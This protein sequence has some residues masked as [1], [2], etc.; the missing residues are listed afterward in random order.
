MGEYTYEKCCSPDILP[1][2]IPITDSADV[3]GLSC[4]TEGFTE[5]I[6][7]SSDASP[8]G[9][10][11]CWMGEYT[12]EKCCFSQPTVPNDIHQACWGGNE[13]FQKICCDPFGQDPHCW[14]TGSTYHD[15]CKRGS[16]EVASLIALR[17]KSV[18]E[19][20]AKPNLELPFQQGP[21]LCQDI[22]N[23]VDK[24]VCHYLRQAEDELLGHQL[25]SSD[26]SCWSGIF[27]RDYCCSQLPLGNPHCWANELTFETCCLNLSFPVSVLHQFYRCENCLSVFQQPSLTC[28]DIAPCWHRGT[29]VAL[30]QGS[31]RRSLFGTAKALV[32][33]LPRLT[34][35]KWT[36]SAAAAV[37][38]MQWVK[39]HHRTVTQLDLFHVPSTTMPEIAVML[40]PWLVLCI[41]STLGGRKHLSPSKVQRIAAIDV[42][43]LI[44]TAAAVLLH[45]NL[46]HYHPNDHQVQNRQ[47][48]WHHALRFTD[49]FGVLSVLVASQ[50]DSLLASLDALWRKLGRQLTLSFLMTRAPIWT[51]GI[52]PHI[53][54]EVCHDQVATSQWS[55][56][57]L[58]GCL[59]FSNETP[60]WY[61]SMDLK[62]WLALRAVH[63]LKQRFSPQVI[64]VLLVFV[65]I[66]LCMAVLPQNNYNSDLYI[67]F[68]TYRLPMTLLVYLFL[69]RREQLQ[70]CALQQP[71]L[72]CVTAASMCGF[73][74]VGCV[75]RVP[76]PGEHI[77]CMH[78]DRWFFVGGVFFHL[79]VAMLC[80][81]PPVSMPGVAH[82]MVCTLSPLAPGIL[83]IHHCVLEVMK[84]CEHNAS[85][86]FFLKTE[87]LYV[88]HWDR[89]D[90]PRWLSLSFSAAS[91]ALCVLTA[92]VVLWTVQRPWEFYWFQCPKH[93]SRA[94][95]FAYLLLFLWKEGQSLDFMRL[96]D[97]TVKRTSAKEITWSIIIVTGRELI[98][99]DAD[100]DA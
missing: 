69:L 63:I 18:L 77:S 55:A 50:P 79:G 59:T 99:S 82:R 11:E 54:K 7:C 24:E 20:V 49:I 51:A 31:D 73:G 23:I 68:W 36:K 89:D 28:Q 60:Q 41:I 53:S 12:Y 5:E 67:K 74:W 87:D 2:V 48:V 78:E 80:L 9:N 21:A 45:M 64:L 29:M 66:S 4:W 76:Q 32:L 72:W 71:W 85:P 3:T 34:T 44:G 62:V 61:L 88:S 46:Y 39:D 94:A 17:E 98:H 96:H 84:R 15:C 37:F 35:E 38:T 26:L 90:S 22:G 57:M 40:G 27:T 93:I 30:S 75:P 33:C 65:I 8:H 25:S 10:P 58:V 13:Q 47:R 81:Q 6:C 70:R 92:Q 100:Q 42:G 43:R 52:C 91:L 19:V 14:E 97:A 86:W 56:R 83:T 16:N 95:V 1:P